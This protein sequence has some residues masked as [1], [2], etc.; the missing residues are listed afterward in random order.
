MTK[1]TPHKNDR[2]TKKDCNRET[3]MERTVEKLLGGLNQLCS[4]E[5]LTNLT[6]FVHVNSN[7]ELAKCPNMLA[8]SAKFVL[9]LYETDVCNCKFYRRNS[10]CMSSITLV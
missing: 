6:K 7:I 9:K 3:T 10:E 8:A 4:R 5:T 2:R 1:Q